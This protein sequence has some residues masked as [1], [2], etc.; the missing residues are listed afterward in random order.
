MKLVTSA[1]PIIEEIGDTKTLII[2]TETSSLFPHKN[3]RILAGIG[4]KPLCGEGFYMPF[5]HSHNIA[6]PNASLKEL[7]RLYEMFLGRTLV[8]FNAPFDLAVLWN[9]GLNLLREDIVDVLVNM[10][11]VTENEPSYELRRLSKK[12]IDDT[13]IEVE[14]NV[15]D[16]CKKMG[17]GYR[18][19]DNEFIYRYDLIPPEILFSP[20][21]R[22]DLRFTENLFLRSMRMIRIN[23]LQDLFA[24]EK[25]VTKALFWMEAR[26]VHMDTKYIAS[27]LASLTKSY[28]KF[29]ADIYNIAGQKFNI[30]ST[31]QL[32][33]IF[34]S[35]NVRSPK[36]T[37]G[38]K[39]KDKKK[40]AWDK[41]VLKELEHPLAEAIIKFRTVKK[42][43]DY[44]VNFEKFMCEGDVIH[45]SLQQAGARTGRFS[46]REPNLQN[47]PVFGGD[48]DP[49]TGEKYSELEASLYGKVRSAFIARPDTFFFIPDY[50]QVELRIF[51]DYADEQ[52]QIK[53][54]ALGLDIHAMVA[55]SAFGDLPPKGTDEYKFKRVIAK[56]IGFGLR[57]GL[58]A[59]GLGKRINKTTDEAKTFK[60]N[61]FARFPKVQLFMDRVQQICIERGYVKNRWGR[62]RYLPPNLSYIAVN[63][64]IQGTAADLMKD[65]MW[66]VDCALEGYQAQTELTIHDELL[67]E[68][69]YSEAELVIPIVMRE[70]EMVDTNKIRVPITCDPS[71]SATSWAAK[72]SMACDTCL[73]KRKLFSESEEDMLRWLY[74]N[75]M[76]RLDSVE[77]TK[78]AD[79]DGT[80]YDITKITRVL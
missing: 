51:A 38:G 40:P 74:E 73:G 27:E 6:Y 43:R 34:T 41:E 21:V 49:V 58:G 44:Y 12:Y 55:L 52:D 37:E 63:F 9:E 24:L 8:F 42:Y 60:A 10:R 72:E 5:R 78:C 20:Y 70:M 39:N 47:I 46:C 30:K 62:R 65:A 7:E 36:L 75:K 64:L 32:G 1:S 25:R 67:I 80:G 22:N 23:D 28:D 71:W 14:K 11:L 69:P 26:G 13:A 57:Y 35:F 54:F 56:N 50:S 31:Q 45:P 33:D 61:Y 17:W 15:H 48:I 4:V 77:T 3:G 19:E 76:D 79:C 68:V 18:D 66:R 59:A 2:D 53:L 16:L 29:E